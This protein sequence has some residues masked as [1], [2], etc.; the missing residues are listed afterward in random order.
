LEHDT[1]EQPERTTRKRRWPRSA[2]LAGGGLIAGGIL[3]GTLVANASTDQATSTTATTSPTATNS[4]SPTASPT[5]PGSTAPDRPR[6]GRDGRHGDEQPLTGDTATSVK[7]AV[8]AKY[9]DATIER[10][11]TDSD[12]VYEAHITTTDGQHITVELDTSFAI[13]GTETFGNGDVRGDHDGDD[14]GRWHGHHGDDG[15]SDDG[16]SNGGGS[17]GGGS[18]SAAPTA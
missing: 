1:T 3:A 7:D 15:D 8:L 9:P 2:A 18:E 6:E 14:P 12:G 17:N 10:V 11:E 5:E 4:A 13:T 16:D